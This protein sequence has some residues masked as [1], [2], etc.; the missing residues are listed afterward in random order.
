ML[1]ITQ[2]FSNSNKI[3]RKAYIFSFIWFILFFF[4]FFGLFGK[5]NIAISLKKLPLNW[6]SLSVWLK[7]PFYVL[8]P[9]KHYFNGK[10]LFSFMVFLK[11]FVSPIY[12]FPM[13]IAF[14]TTQIISLFIPFRDFCYSI[15][16]LIEINKNV[17]NQKSQCHSNF[18]FHLVLGIFILIIFFI[19]NCQILNRIYFYKNSEKIKYFLLRL[20]ENFFFFTTSIFSTLIFFTNSKK[21]FTLLWICFLT[22]SFIFSFFVDIIYNWRIFS[23]K[24][25]KSIIT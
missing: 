15:C 23:I 18:Y 14:A 22:I 19:R 25:V 17:K 1:K 13:L 4:T 20:F 2:T 9:Q 8:F 16:F 21:I 5:G 7:Y 24:K 6:I 11:I 12:K 3:L 10:F